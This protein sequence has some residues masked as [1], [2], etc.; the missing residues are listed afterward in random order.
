M[1]VEYDIF[2][3]RSLRA[4]YIAG[5]FGGLLKG[6]ILDVGCGRAAIRTLLPDANYTGIDIGGKSDFVVNLERIDRFPSTTSP[7][8]AWSAPTFWNIW[9]TCIIPLAS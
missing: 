6:K 9:T 5:R 2:A 3:D 7:S 1:R 8:M 4:R